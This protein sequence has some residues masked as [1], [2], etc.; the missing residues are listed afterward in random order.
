MVLTYSYVQQ[1]TA[2]KEHCQF[3]AR[4]ISKLSMADTEDNNL[5][6]AAV[7]ANDDDSDVEMEG[8]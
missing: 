1:S 6:P 3:I 4:Q 7:A 2:S 8:E 5:K